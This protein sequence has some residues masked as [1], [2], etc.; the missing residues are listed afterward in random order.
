MAP[1]CSSVQVGPAPVPRTHN[2]LPGTGRGRPCEAIGEAWWVG[3]SGGRREQA[4]DDQR[5]SRCRRRCGGISR[6][7]RAPSTTS[8]WSISTMP[9]RPRSRRRSSTRS[10]QAYGA[11]YA[12]VHRGLHFLSNLGDREIRGGARDRPPLHQRGAR[13]TRSIFTRNATEAINLAAASFGGSVIGEGDEIVLS[14]MEHHSNIVP[15]NFL[16][17]QRGAVIKW[18]PVADDGTFLVDEFEKLL[19]ARARRWWRSPTCRTCSAR[20][21]R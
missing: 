12:N 11:E 8:R 6:F 15:W 18:A 13:P 10:P 2:P 9:P 4:R 19:D 20:S 14:I 3:C 1:D 21:C 17:E 7:W 5:A 16:R